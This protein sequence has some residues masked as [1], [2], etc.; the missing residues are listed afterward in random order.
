MK[1]IKRG[2][3][4]VFA[5]FAAAPLWAQAP[6]LYGAGVEES[7]ILVRAVNA[8]TSPVELRIGAQLLAAASFGDATPYKPIAA[9]IYTLFHAGKRWEFVPDLSS[10]YTLVALPD[11]LVILKDQRHEDPAKA[12][13]Y[14]Y[15]LMAS[16][17]LELKTADGSVRILGPLGALSS[18]QVAV[19]ALSVPV[20]VFGTAKLGQNVTLN[21]TRGSSWSVFVADTAGGPRVFAVTASVDSD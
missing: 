20:A 19:N 21:L 15:N 10:Y 3:L 14:F 1:A 17:G 6:S 12:Q 2:L 16:G 4:A 9:D 11:R 13:L 18:A 8:G 5:L 7:A